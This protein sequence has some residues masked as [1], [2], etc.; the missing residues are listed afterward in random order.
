MK[1]GIVRYPG[2]NCDHDTLR[3]FK[4]SFFIWHQTS[5]LPD[6]DLL[7]IPGGFAF[8]DR[9]YSSA[10]GRYR[11]DPGQKALKS[12]V[13]K[14]IE[15]AH[16]KGIPILGICNGFQI[17]VKMGLLPGPLVINKDK[18]FHSYLRTCAFEDG[19]EFD[20]PIANKYGFFDYPIREDQIILKYRIDKEKDD[21]YVAGVRD[22]DR[23][24]FGIMPHPERLP[25]NE[26]LKKKLMD[27]IFPK[28]DEEVIKRIMH[29]E[30]VSYKSTKKYLSMLPTEAEHVIQGPGE[31]AGI[32]DIG[33]GYAL[34]LRIESHNHPIYIDPYQGAA[35]GAGGILRDIFTM[36]ARPIALF[37]FLRFG[38]DERA[39]LIWLLNNSKAMLAVLIHLFKKETLTLKNY[40]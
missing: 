2:S 26:E 14:V 4:G 7:V 13:N 5:K 11:I 22:L 10:T 3:Y 29:S 16:K 15:D 39:V 38:T 33:D 9:V 32:I 35:T 28:V 37:D 34:A 25:Y 20:I 19:T 31:N 1:I 6:I 30:H 40:F 8:G 36:G 27:T 21:G 23:K 12:P 24:V 17:L 18:K